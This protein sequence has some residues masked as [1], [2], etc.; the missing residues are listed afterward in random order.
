MFLDKFKMVI[1]D[2]YYIYYSKEKNEILITE[3]EVNYNFISD[4]KIRYNLELK[5]KKIKIK[6]IFK[7]LNKDEKIINEE[8]KNWI[9]ERNRNIIGYKFKSVTDKKQNNFCNNLKF[10]EMYGLENAYKVEL[11]VLQTYDNTKKFEKS[12]EKNK[13]I[14]YGIWDIEKNEI[15][16]SYIW[17]SPIQTQMCSPDFFD[18][19][20]KRGSLFVKIKVIKKI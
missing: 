10:S 18:L 1:R 2:K 9:K 15:N 12:F 4:S 7:I 19:D 20:L 14:V 11:E 16:T 3:E 5:D 6:D 13:D 8:L 17:K